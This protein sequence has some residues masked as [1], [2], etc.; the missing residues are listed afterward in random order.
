MKISLD[1][2]NILRNSLAKVSNIKESQRS[3]K[4]PKPF[5]TTSFTNFF[6]KQ[7]RIS[8]KKNDEYCSETISG[9][10]DYLY[11]NG[12]NKTFRCCNQSIEYISSNFSSEHLPSEPNFYG[13]SK[14]AQA[15]HEAIRPSGESFTTP[16]ELLK[17]YKEDS[18]EFKLYE[19][20]FNV[21]IA[22]QMSEARGI[23]KQ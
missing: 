19:L 12:F 20:I 18:D 17:K 10:F 3:G 21:T 8:T 7:F 14:N 9:G 23:Q 22:S 1:I 16:Q 15:A 4:P 13:D 6:K 11:E 2:V 5:K